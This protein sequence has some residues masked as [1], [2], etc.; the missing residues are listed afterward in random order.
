MRSA[1]FGLFLIVA[2]CVSAALGQ[3]QVIKESANPSPQRS[4]TSQAPATSTAIVGGTLVDVHNGEEIENSVVIIRGER[5]AKVGVVDKLEI[6]NDARVV[7]AHG[8][9]ILPGLIDMH[10]HLWDSD[11]LPLGLFLAN[12]ITTIRDPGY[13][14]LVMR[15]TREEITSGKRIGPR[16]F[17]CGDLLDGMPPLYRESTLLVDTPERAHSAVMFLADQGVDCIKVY[18]SVKEPELKEIIRTAHARNLPVIGHIP[19]TLTMTHA[20]ELGM[21]GLEHIRVTG[22]EMLPIEEANKIDFLPFA[23]RETLL[24][25]Q[26]EP[27]SEKMKRL[28]RFLAESNIILDP[29]LVADGSTFLLSQDDQINNPNN[30]YL[31]PQLFN[32]WKGEPVPQF[33]KLPA[34]LKQVAIDGFEKRKQFVGMCSRAGVHIIAGSD[35]AGLGTL[36]PG[37][38]LQHELQLLVQSGLTPL[39]AI[40]AATINSA[41]A[42][43]KEHDLGVIEP[44]YFADV[45]IL[46]ADPIKEISNTQ[47]ID[48]VIEAGRPY[49]PLDLLNASGKSNN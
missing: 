36:L 46:E 17:F 43:G 27:Q 37:F 42:L 32:K 13:S 3:Q 7:D 29:T 9:W 48:L 14:V 19:R 20:V 5:V 28:V 25:K 38:G 34:E 10:V 49:K 1:C 45:L 41:A 23:E 35:G 22:R 18:N 39:Q 21:Q 4:M 6:P 8:K 30:R 33:D 2:M 24:W 40:Q 44:G 47:K 31:P 12:G 15:L 16:L 26:F 11:L